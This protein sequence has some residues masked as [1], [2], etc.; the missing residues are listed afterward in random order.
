M[1]NPGA[2]PGLLATPDLIFL[3]QRIDGESH[4]VALD[5]ENGKALW[6][7]RLMG[8]H[9]SAPPITF[10]SGGKQFV[11]LATGAPHETSKLLAFRLP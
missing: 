4:L 10:T 1:G 3:G 7:H 11:V 9:F 8:N 2:A 5:R 6:N